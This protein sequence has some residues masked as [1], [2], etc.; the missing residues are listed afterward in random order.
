MNRD[1]RVLLKTGHRW[2]A[3][4]LVSF[5]T[6]ASF[7]LF[8]TT[9]AFSANTPKSKAVS[10]STK[11]AIVNC[12]ETLSALALPIQKFNGQD[13]IMRGQFSQLPQAPVI[14]R[15]F[16]GDTFRV[17][18]VG[19]DPLFPLAT[20]DTASIRLQTP[21][22]RGE[23]AVPALAGPPRS[24]SALT[25]AEKYK[26]AESYVRKTWADTPLEAAAI[27]RITKATVSDSRLMAPALKQYEA[28]TLALEAPRPANSIGF[29]G[30][31][32]QSVA[33]PSG[34][35]REM[36]SGG[37]ISPNQA[38]AVRKQ[39]MDQAE[40]SSAKENRHFWFTPHGESK[41]VP[42]RILDLHVTSGGGARVYA[43]WIPEQVG[44]T[45]R[46]RHV[47]MIDVSEIKSI[48]KL[49]P[50]LRMEAEAIFFESLTP[51]QLSTQMLA[52]RLGI[53]TRGHTDFLRAPGVSGS[54]RII[55]DKM[56]V[57]GHYAIRE[58][59]EKKFG[60]IT[61]LLTDA[62]KATQNWNVID[63]FGRLSPEYVLKRFRASDGYKYMYVITEDGQLKICP[64]GDA[65][66]NLRPQILRLGHGRKIY[67]AGMFTLDNNGSANVSLRTADYASFDSQVVD[68]LKPPQNEDK[69]ARAIFRM[70]ANT[71]V[72]SVNS[73]APESWSDMKMNFAT[74][75]YEHVN[76]IDPPG[77]AAKD[78]NS[79]GPQPNQSERNSEWGDQ[80]TADY[81]DSLLKARAKPAPIKDWDR[82][83]LKALP[84]TFEE[85]EKTARRSTSGF[86]DLE[87]KMDYAHYVLGTNDKMEIREIKAAYQKLIQKYSVRT[88]EGSTDVVAAQTINTAYKVF[89]DR[90]LEAARK[91]LEAA[92]A[93]AR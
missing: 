35:S 93:A 74:G 26:L 46:V 39:N 67:S 82:E 78:T 51:D 32:S 90:E 68:A 10:K 70:Q 17:T 64:I 58:W 34:S 5:V 76:P 80:A 28:G 16:I 14:P 85:W 7:C 43:E 4:G 66:A 89:K 61:D 18:G 8:L 9:P 33:A 53:S 15:E 54:E 19:G 65:G 40:L 20:G 57:A 48:P 83:N 55:T 13:T 75:R 91:R 52:S 79:K 87:N 6:T 69:L 77:A 72:N 47:G 11:T 25:A 73:V 27:E 86:S 59:V 42:A 2:L 84:P 29:S 1:V 50:K 45:E 81:M 62:E 56:S 22:M 37:G 88:S 31:R 71:Q 30:S 3:A 60:D 41:A 12:A 92:E 36:V 44:R 23:S 21:G 24:A 63:V 49:S 38:L